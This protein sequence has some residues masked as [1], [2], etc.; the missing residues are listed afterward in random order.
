M[1]IYKVTVKTADGTVIL[2]ENGDNEAYVSELYM[3]CRSAGWLRLVVSY[4]KMKM[5]VT[6]LRQSCVEKRICVWE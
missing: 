3:K 5:R 2:A 4:V 1:F 6:I